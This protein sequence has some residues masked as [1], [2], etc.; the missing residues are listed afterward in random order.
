[1]DAQRGTSI[2]TD[3][4]EI[5]SGTD[6]GRG[7]SLNAIMRME[8]EHQWRLCDHLRAGRLIEAQQ[9]V[10]VAL[11]QKVVQ[12]PGNC[13]KEVRNQMVRLQNAWDLASD[14]ARTRWAKRLEKRGD[15]KK[16]GAKL[17]NII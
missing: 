17:E 3:V 11:Q 10:N 12:L 4:L 5:V 1:M 16:Y 2:P 7:K 13:T 9:M 8:P 14:N 6:L 15:L